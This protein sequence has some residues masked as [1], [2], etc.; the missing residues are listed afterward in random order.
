MDTGAGEGGRPQ[1]QR[2][3]VPAGAAAQGGRLGAL[4]RGGVAA[5]GAGG[6][7][8]GSARGRERARASEGPLCLLWEA[9]TREM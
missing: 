5:P 2:A 4:A 6:M 1:G 7:A 9:C 3:T 8:W